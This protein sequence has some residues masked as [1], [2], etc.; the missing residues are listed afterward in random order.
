MNFTSAGGGVL[1]VT[2]AEGGKVMSG[3]LLSLTGNPALFR[4]TSK[5][6]TT[7]TVELVA[8]NGSTLT[9]STIVT[10]GG[11]MKIVSTPAK[12]GSANGDGE[13]NY[14]QTGTEYNTTQIFRKEIQ[15]TGT[16]LATTVYGGVDNNINRQTVFALGD[17]TRDLNRVALFGRRVQGTSGGVRG[18]AGGLYLFG[19]QSGGM[20]IDAASAMFDD[21]IVNDGA[22]AVIGEGGNPV[23]ILCSPS[24]ARVLSNVYKDQIQI[25]R[26]DEKRGAYVAVIVNDINGRG[27]TIMADPDM[28]DT[29]AW[30]IDPDG[31]SRVPMQGRDIY[32]E[33]ATPKG[34]DGI[35]R[36]ALGEL[37]FVFKNAK[38]RLCRIKNLKD[39]MVALAAIKAGLSKSV[40]V[41][42]TVE[43]TR[44][45]NVAADAAVPTAAAALYGYRVKIV[46]G[47][48]G[49]TNIATAVAGEVYACNGTAWIKQ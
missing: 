41:T 12:E 44:T 26:A 28:P 9:A 46:T 21:V 36:M 37:T 35:L 18:E 7:L 2:E 31:F 6:T 39:S 17:L 23:Q 47:W 29:D 34:H 24:Q 15:V 38:Q 42:N 3:T 40:S 22:Q 20:V 1:T 4:V 14:H 33:D 10:T 25:V 16:A 30:I 5:G 45:I 32:D 27:M 48:T 49:G 19:T 13:Q 11:I 43:T 8:S